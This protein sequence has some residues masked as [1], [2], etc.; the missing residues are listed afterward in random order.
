MLSPRS[1]LVLAFVSAIGF[2]LADAVLDTVVFHKFSLGDSILRPDF[3]EVYVRLLGG[4][5]IIVGGVRWSRNVVRMST[6]QADLEASR[7]RYVSLVESLPEAVAVADG[8][9]IIFANQPC[10]DLIGAASLE[11]LPD[12]DVLQF[13]HPEDRG[14]AEERLARFTA[15]HD[16]LPPF[17]LRIMRLDGSEAHLLVAAGA[18]EFQGPRSLLLFLRDI[19]DEIETRR[20]LL[21]SRE[22]LSLALDAA[23]DGVWDWD[24]PSGTMVYNR[25][26]AS[27]LGLRLEDVPP[28]Q[29]TWMRILHPDDRPREE[30]LLQSHLR[31]EI[32]N[33][34]TEV[35]ARHAKG[36]YIWVLDRG[37]VVERDPAGRALRMTGT[38]R[39]ITARKEAEIALAVRNQLAET[40][41]TVRGQGLYTEILEVLCRSLSSPTGLLGTFDKAGNLRVAAIRP[42]ADEQPTPPVT[43]EDLGPRLGRAVQKQQSVRD[44]AT[45]ILPGF[46]DPVAGSLTVPIASRDEVLGLVVVGDRSEPY[47]PTDQALLESVVGYLAPM[48]Q[49]RQANETTEAQLRQAQKMEALGVLAGGIAHDF[50]N[51]LQAIHGFASLAAEDAAVDSHLAHDLERILKA[52]NRGEDLV[53]R[54]LLFSRREEQEIR[55]LVMAEVVQEAVDFLV[56]T[57]PGKIKIEARVAEDA[58]EVLGDPSQLNQVLMNLATNAVHAM[59]ADGGTLAFEL[60]RSRPDDERPGLHAFLQDKDLLVLQ[61]SDTGTG[62]DRAT[63]DR[64]FDPFFTTKEVGRG[65][66]LGLSMVHGIVVAHGGDVH[67]ASETERGTEVTIYLPRHV[68]SSRRE[69]PAPAARAGRILLVEDDAAAAEVAAS[70]LEIGGHD[71]AIRY[72]GE[73]ALAALKEFEEDYDLVITD[74]LMPGVN[75][76]QVAEGTAA[77]RPDL[78]VMLVTGS[79]EDLGQLAGWRQPPECVVAVVQK[80]FN[81]DLLR[82]AVARAL[83]PNE[84]AS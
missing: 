15:G 20:D 69:T 28:D 22:R 11:M 48:L 13:V 26:W 67:I 51:I 68:T 23:R 75:G 70:I 45:A 39:E 40:F 63:L 10:L 77:I 62:M 56:P 38:H 29:S 58:G 18:V 32:P 7:G 47:G 49:D 54:I 42:R 79:G 1:I 34:E 44:P 50:N 83:V 12:R 6:M 65:T 61:V 46:A 60:R 71:V 24:I 81:G 76:L 21:A 64:L 4:I 36:H 3:H 52:A 33:Y 73:S 37:R 9:R 35:R 25:A 2:W 30:T 17:E 27:M 14:I 59:E 8:R 72:D 53:R 41:L 55:P 43:P 66:G 84:T 16:T 19:G 78:P 80:P 74:V 5:I 82:H 31:G 57:V